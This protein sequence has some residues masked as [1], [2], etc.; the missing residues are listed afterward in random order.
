M[1]TPKQAAGSASRFRR[2]GLRGSADDLA[3]ALKANGPAGMSLLEVGGGVGQIQVALLESGV[4]STATNVE[5][6]TSW[7][8]TARALLDERGLQRRVE[9]IVGDFVDQAQTLQQA[10][11]VILHRVV[12]CYPDWKAMFQP[13]RPRPAV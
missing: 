2:K 11:A 4:A 9:R 10:D 8:D 1:F 7:E 5:L 6:S 12:C 13:P 3:S